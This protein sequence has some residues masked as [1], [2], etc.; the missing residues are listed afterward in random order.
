MCD[1]ECSGAQRVRNLFD[2][3]MKRSRR[4]NVGIFGRVFGF[5][6]RKSE[7]ENDNEQETTIVFIDEIDAIGNR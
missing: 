7:D 1:I 2:E 5:F 4:K 3:A 6:S